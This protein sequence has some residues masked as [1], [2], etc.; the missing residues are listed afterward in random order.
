ML[1]KLSAWA[2]HLLTASGVL[3]AILTLSEIHEHHFINALWLMCVAIFIDAIDGTFARIVDIKV[4]LPQIDGALLDNI[5][6]FLNY[7][8]TPCFFLLLAP[9]QLP[10]ML[11]WPII[12]GISLSSSYQFTQQD[13]KTEDH[14]FKGFPCYWNIVVLYLYVFSVPAN[15]GGFVLLLLCALVFL[16]VKYVY[17]SRLNYLSKKPW[18]KALML[19]GSVLFGFHCLGMLAFYPNIPWYLILYSVVYILFYTTFSLLRTIVPL[20]KDRT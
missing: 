19:I 7:V 13:A 4:T 2:V 11:I 8:V 1:K 5:V 20:M 12:I 10:S 15:I 3:V 14:F 6:D 17:P 18:L 9:N 16:P